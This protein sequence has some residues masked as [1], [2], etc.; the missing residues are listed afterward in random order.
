[1]EER[2]TYS[3]TGLDTVI[4]STGRR[5]WK[6]EVEG[7]AIALLTLQRQPAGW[8]LGAQLVFN[9]FQLQHK[10]LCL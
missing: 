4:G 1:M 8:A 2:G 6:C 9:T 10:F 7:A 5:F 3:E